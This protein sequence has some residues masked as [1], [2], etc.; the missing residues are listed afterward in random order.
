LKYFRKN[1]G[2]NVVDLNNEK[3]LKNLLRIGQIYEDGLMMKDWISYITSPK[4]FMLG[5]MEWKMDD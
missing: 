4:R 3:V 2:N 1:L 5:F